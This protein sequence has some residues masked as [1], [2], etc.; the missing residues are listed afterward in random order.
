MELKAYVGL[1]DS[2]DDFIWN[3]YC[4]EDSEYVGRFFFYNAQDAEKMRRGAAR[5]NGLWR[6][7]IVAAASGFGAIGGWSVMSWFTGKKIIP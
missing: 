3:V 7:S 6:A 1:V 2:G 5:A 4:F